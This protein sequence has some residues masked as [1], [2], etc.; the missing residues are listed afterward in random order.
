MIHATSSFGSGHWCHRSFGG[1]VLLRRQD[2]HTSAQAGA[3]CASGRA[4][5]SLKEII[6]PPPGMSYK[7]AVC[8]V[9]NHQGFAHMWLCHASDTTMCPDGCEGSPTCDDY[10]DRRRM[11]EN[12]RVWFTRSHL[13]AY[14]RGQDDAR[15]D[16]SPIFRQVGDRILPEFDDDMSDK[17]G[18]EERQAYI[19]GYNS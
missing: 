11:Y 5:N 2:P 9:N 19:D 6:V 15:C 18:D 7:L 14:K 10:S 8:L 17:W 13:S 3:M 4:L 16:K 1:R 12:I